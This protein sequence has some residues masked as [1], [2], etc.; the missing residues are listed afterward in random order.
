MSSFQK[1]R[2]WNRSH[3]FG[4][5][6]GV[7]FLSSQSAYEFNKIGLWLNKP[8][9]LFLD[10]L[11]P[12]PTQ[13]STN[14]NNYSNYAYHISLIESSIHHLQINFPFMQI[15]ITCSD[16]YSAYRNQYSTCASEFSPYANQYSTY[17][18]I[19]STCIAQFSKVC[20]LIFHVCKSIF[21]VCKLTFYF[22][23]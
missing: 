20:K 18:N 23:P 15:N 1:P 11:L 22:Y 14:A 16:Q 17:A 19:F 12:F 5:K 21:H 13:V 7:D 10:I 8:L 6:S 2:I 9:S 4:K 3:K